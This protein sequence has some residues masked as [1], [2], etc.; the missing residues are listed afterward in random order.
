MTGKVLVYGGTGGIGSETARLLR[1]KGY[2]LHIVGRSAEKVEAL[3]NELGASASIADLNDPGAFA[4]V[5]AEA[6]P[7]L[8]GLVYAVGTINPKPLARLT[9]ADFEA[10]FRLN[11]MGAALAVQAA[12][13]ALKA[14][15]GTSS[16]LLF[17]TVAVAQGFS[18]HASVSMAK[19]AVEGLARA[20]AAELAPKIRVNA[21]APSLTRTPLAAGLTSQ[22]A[23]AQALG[24]MHPMGRL[25][26]A[27]DTARLAAFLI[28]E[29]A[30]WITG[31][32]IGVDGGRSSLRTK[33]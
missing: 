16:V 32:I 1:E 13:P 6:G 25:G 26:E 20:L 10:D 27:I 31:Q 15:S 24:Q 3:A 18:S 7:E 8:A 33:G 17:S 22:P 9:P 30:G 5:T 19:G 4:T 11:A 2:D 28:S 14:G 12:L 21:I 29:E 23:M